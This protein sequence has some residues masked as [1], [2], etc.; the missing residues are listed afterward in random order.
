MKL[1][2]IVAVVQDEGDDGYWLT[3][4]EVAFDEVAS[5][6][7]AVDQLSDLYDEALASSIEKVSAPP[8]LASRCC[9]RATLPQLHKLA[10]GPTPLQ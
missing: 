9:M 8:T 4:P 2:T 10:L 3:S 7:Q 6:W 5:T 1:S